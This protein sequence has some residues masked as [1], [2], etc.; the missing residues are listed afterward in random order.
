MDLK[1]IQLLFLLCITAS[2]FT[3]NKPDKEYEVV[4][5]IEVRHYNDGS[6]KIVVDD[7]KITLRETKK[8]IYYNWF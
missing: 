4:S 6:K 2:F 3:P 7:S 5:T 1:V 8:I